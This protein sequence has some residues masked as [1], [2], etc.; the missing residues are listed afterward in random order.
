[1]WCFSGDSY[2]KLEANY[3]HHDNDGDDDDDED[4]EEDDEDDYEIDRDVKKGVD[5]NN[6][7]LDSPKIDQLE[8]HLSNGSNTNYPVARKTSSKHLS[9]D[10]L[11]KDILVKVASHL[12]IRDLM[13][14]EHTNR[15]L[16]CCISH[17]W[18]TFCERS[19]I[20]CDPTPLCVG[21]PLNTQSLYSYD[22]ATV[23][24]QDPIKK[25]RVA[26]MRSLLVG[27]FC[28]VVCGQHL[29]DRM[30][31]DGI[32]FNH[33]V[34]LCFPDCFHIFTVNINGPVV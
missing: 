14:L 15:S 11:P 28:C 27:S 21:W 2:S 7:N 19:C 26:A 24:C 34:L 16:K 33:D 31:V 1:M 3:E 5:N 18:K 8:N 22:N 23:F 29:K 9:L 6:F 20:P 10:T 30:S 4:D 12:D 17:Y 32:Y 13:C 25:W